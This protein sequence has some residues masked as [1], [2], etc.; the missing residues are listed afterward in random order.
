MSDK[1]GSVM[2]DVEEELVMPDIPIR[3][4]NAIL[5]SIGITLIQSLLI[6]ASYAF[7]Y[8]GTVHLLDDSTLT[9]AGYT[10]EQQAPIQFIRDSGLGQTLGIMYSVMTL[11]LIISGI[12]LMRKNPLGVKIGIGS[13]AIFVLANIV[14]N[15]W[16][17][18]FADDYGLKAQIGSATVIQFLC[19]AFC[20]A[21]PLVAIL[22]PEGRAALYREKVSLKFSEEE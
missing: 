2:M 13:G 6:A 22:I 21:L 8:L 5:F 18:M 7:V 20:M 17:H 10:D 11:G 4:N 15:V 9:E 1:I 12:L 14:D 3:P 19:G 16:K